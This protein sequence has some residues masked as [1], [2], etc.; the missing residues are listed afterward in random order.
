M[1]SLSKLYNSNMP[2]PYICTNDT[3]SKIRILLDQKKDADSPKAVR[4][5]L[6][7]EYGFYSSSLERPRDGFTSHHFNEHIKKGNI[8]IK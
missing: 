6:R 4:D 1:A 2:L 8:V 3:A 5:I 7:N